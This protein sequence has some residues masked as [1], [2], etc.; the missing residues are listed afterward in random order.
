MLIFL[1]FIV[2]IFFILSAFFS[3]IE[4]GLIS[5][6]RFKLEQESK[7]D[8]KKKQI[9]H[10]LENPDKLFGTTLFGTNISVVIVS[11]ICMYLI[12]HYKELR[13]I[14]ISENTG[15][16]IVAGLLLIFAE[17]IPKAVYRERPIKLVT[18]FFPVF[19]FFYVIFKPFVTFVRKFY[20]WL[21][22]RLLA[23][24][25]LLNCRKQFLGDYL[26]D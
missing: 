23:E 3:G 24:C 2:V 22:N 25:Y 14:N 7:S 6:D 9:L 17:I 4:T 21:A 8:N 10:F 20:S 11:S 26:Y 16:L 13:I 15:T 5:I 12:H 1:L 19:K 18:Q